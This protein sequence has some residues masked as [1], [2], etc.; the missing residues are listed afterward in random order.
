MRRSIAPAVALLA[1]STIVGCAA[2]PTLAQPVC[3]TEQLSTLTIMAQSVR[4]AAMVP[5]LKGIPAGWSFQ[6]LEVRQNRSQM[7]L[8][9]DRAGDHALQVTLAKTCNTS[10]AVRIPSDEPQTERYENILRISPAYVATRS[11]VFDGGCVTYR[12]ELDTDRPSTLVNEATL[13]VGFATRTELRD[14]IRRES[15]GQIKDGP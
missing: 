2:E 7:R 4:T 10:G 3:G 13:M 8:A 5:C 15:H 11:Y 6:K 9:S 12:F 1:G 14:A